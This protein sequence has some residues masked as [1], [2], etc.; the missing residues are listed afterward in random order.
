LH[1]QAFDPPVASIGTSLAIGSSRTGNGGVEDR[2]RAR[3]G[4]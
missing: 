2:F 1:Q 3:N 4:L